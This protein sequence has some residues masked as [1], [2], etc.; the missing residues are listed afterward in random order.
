MS[1]SNASE[2]FAPVPKGIV[3]IAPNSKTATVPAV[4]CRGGTE[5][6]NKKETHWRITVRRNARLERKGEAMKEPMP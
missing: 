1:P 3:V 5:F 4:K 6:T 2:R